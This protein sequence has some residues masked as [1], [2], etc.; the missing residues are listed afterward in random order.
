MGAPVLSPPLS[1]LVGLPLLL[2]LPFD[3]DGISFK[4]AATAVLLFSASIDDVG[5]ED[6]G[7]AGD[8]DDDGD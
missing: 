3:D 2:L 7:K 8:N 5:N 1:E 4:P 6:E